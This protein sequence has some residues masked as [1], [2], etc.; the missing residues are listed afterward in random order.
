M[1]EIQPVT[2]GLYF[3]TIVGIYV[4]VFASSSY[5]LGKQ[6]ESLSQFY[7][8]QEIPVASRW[9]CPGQSELPDHDHGIRHICSGFYDQQQLLRQ[10]LLGLV[11]RP[12]WEW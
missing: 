3:L 10:I 8:V 7:L 1:L 4:N 6:F 2:G 5:K 9:L 11:E 12:L